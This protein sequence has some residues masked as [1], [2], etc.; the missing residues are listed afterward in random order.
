MQHKK[1]KSNP[2]KVTRIKNI[3][4]SNLS[5]SSSSSDNHIPTSFKISMISN[6]QN[7]RIAVIKCTSVN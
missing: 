2:C 4:N 5:N 6:I 3:K 1:M 7:E